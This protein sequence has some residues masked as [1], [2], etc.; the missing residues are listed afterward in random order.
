[1]EEGNRE[2]GR[3]ES[4]ERRQ[5]IGEGGGEGGRQRGGVSGRGKDQ[6]TLLIISPRSS[7][8]T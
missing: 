7:H 3:G 1:M 8:G 6:L 2:K 4:R 5:T